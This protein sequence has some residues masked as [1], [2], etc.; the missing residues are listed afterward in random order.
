MDYDILIVEDDPSI[1]RILEL[2]FKHESYQVLVAK[3]GKEAMSLFHENSFSVILLDLMLP[4]MSGFEVCRRIRKE[5]NTPIIMVTARRDVTDKVIGLDAGAD[6]YITKPF[7]MEELLARI[8]ANMRKGS[9][10]KSEDNLLQYQD[11][12][13][14]LL[15]HQCIYKKVVIEL[16]KTEFGLLQ[17]LLTNKG[18][19]LTRQ[20]I[21]DHVWGYDFYGDTNILDVYIRYLRNKLDTDREEPIIHTVRGVGFTIHDQA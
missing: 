18:I 17:Y 15:T 10:R 6:D 4:E 20:Q 14:N 21:I 5:S 12:V 9:L 8:R 19:V 7:V 2:E 16:T 3:N 11:L 13:L 1:S